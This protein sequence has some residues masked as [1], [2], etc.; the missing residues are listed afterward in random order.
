M[1]PAHPAPIGRRALGARNDRSTTYTE[2]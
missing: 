2:T 1:D